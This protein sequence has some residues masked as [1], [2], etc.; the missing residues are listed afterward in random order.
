VPAGNILLR[1]NLFGK[2]RGSSERVSHESQVSTERLSGG[3]IVMQDN[4]PAEV[5][6]PGSIASIVTCQETVELIQ[7]RFDQLFEDLKSKGQLGI[8]RDVP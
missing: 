5:V 2:R 7:R 6:S 3:Q 1:D 4:K 8:R